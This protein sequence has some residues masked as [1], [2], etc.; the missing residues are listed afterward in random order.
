M[1]SRYSHSDQGWSRRSIILGFQ[2]PLDSAIGNAALSNSHSVNNKAL[3][4]SEKSLR[5]A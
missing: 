3:F 4:H 5:L 2:D 1:L